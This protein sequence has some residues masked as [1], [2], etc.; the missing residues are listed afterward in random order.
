MVLMEASEHDDFSV[1]WRIGHREVKIEAGRP[2]RSFCNNLDE[3]QSRLSL[4]EDRGCV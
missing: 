2:S 1:L 4:G 3:G